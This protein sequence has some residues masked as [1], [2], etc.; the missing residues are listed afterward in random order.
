MSTV[1]PTCTG[2]I[3]ADDLLLDVRTAF[4]SWRAAQTATQRDAAMVATLQNRAEADKTKRD[5][6]RTAVDHDE[7]LRLIDG[8]DAVPINPKRDALLAKLDKSASASLAAIAIQAARHRSS[9][10][11]E[12]EPYTSFVGSVLRLTAA[13]R[14]DGFEDILAIL[15]NAAVPLQRIIA[16]D[17]IRRKLIGDRY[18]IPTG[19]PPP[20]SGTT[21]IRSFLNSVPEKMRP[22]EL[23]ER[24][25][26]AAAQSLIE[27]VIHQVKE[28]SQ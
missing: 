3:V 13:V 19:A 27:S 25:I 21:S 7:A 12:V 22:P 23:S 17:E 4:E 8:D 2:D 26:L 9:E 24:E 16:A 18:P 14:G 15:T 28:P 6:L 20:F 5:E 10:A 11:A 1:N